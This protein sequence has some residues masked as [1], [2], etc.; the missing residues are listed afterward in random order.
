MELVE[1]YVDLIAS[2]DEAKIKCVLHSAA[3]GA[4]SGGILLGKAF[5]PTSAIPGGLAINGT[6]AAVGAVLGAL[7]AGSMAYDLCGG[8]ET[9]GNLERLFSM[10]RAPTK[11]IVEFERNLMLEF[12]LTSQQARKLSALA[13]F[14]NASAPP[15][16]MGEVSQIDR[17][18]AVSTLLRS[19]SVV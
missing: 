4:L 2:G 14:Y 18:N 6:A 7:M 1:D 15:R 12:D 17:R 8:P 5:A 3:G 19:A 10:G 16:S 13:V 11:L 9:R